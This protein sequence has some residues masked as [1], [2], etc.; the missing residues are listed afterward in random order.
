[1]SWN[2]SDNEYLKLY[3]KTLGW[4]WYTDVSTKVLF[5]HCL[6]RANWKAGT[7]K[8]I[9]YEAGQFITSI[10]SLSEETGLTVKQV[11]TALKNLK[12]TGEVASKGHS[13]YSVITVKNWDR[14]QSEGTQKGKQGASKGQTEGNRYKK[15]R[16]KEGKNI[17]FVAVQEKWNTLPQPISKVKRIAEGTVRHERLQDLVDIHGDDT[18]LEAI[19]NIKRSGFLQGNGENGWVISFDWFLDPEHFQKVLE[20][21][22]TDKAEQ[23]TEPEEDSWDRMWRL[24][25][26]NE[27]QAG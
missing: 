7:W 27:N 24:Y 19:E 6:L 25:R 4:G 21:N 26:E 16:S 17:Y 1:M 18:V 12:M 3:R 5:F 9:P 2:Y 22:Y 23:E 11:R 10:K 20:G 14:Y 13:K 15:I 8:G